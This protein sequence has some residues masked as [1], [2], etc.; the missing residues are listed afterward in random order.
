MQFP[1][2]HDYEA[3]LPGM[4]TPF[5]RPQ[6]SLSKEIGQTWL[7]YTYIALL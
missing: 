2:K 1:Q 7:S 3:P 4:A 6:N 5:I